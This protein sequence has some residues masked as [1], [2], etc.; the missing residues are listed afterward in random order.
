MGEILPFVP[1]GEV[2]ESEIKVVL[3][4]PIALYKAMRKIVDQRGTTL[5]EGLIKAAGLLVTLTRVSESKD[6]GLYTKKLTEDGE[7]VE[8]PIV[9]DWDQT[10]S[11][12][13]QKHPQP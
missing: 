11:E 12:W 5:S 1:K 4:L 7:T 13:K 6:E 2:E 3:E 10:Y 8:L 9:F